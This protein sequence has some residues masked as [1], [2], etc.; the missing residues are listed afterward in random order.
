M[1]IESNNTEPPWA[2]TEQRLLREASSLGELLAGLRERI[3]TALISGPGWDALL[4]RA[5]DLPASLAAFPF[6]FELPLHD[7]TP[8][9]DLGVSLVCGSASATAYAQR[10]EDP[11]AAGIVRLLA[12][13]ARQSSALRR[14]TGPKMVLEYDIDA[15]DRRA[16]PPPG[17]F[18]YPT[19][20]P[21]YGR[22]ASRRLGDLGVVLDG[23][24]A[25]GWPWN[26]AE[27]RQV[28]RVY[29]VAGADNRVLSIGAFPARRRAIRLALA[30]FESADDVVAFLAR[31]QWPYE[32][33]TVRSTLT[34]LQDRGISCGIAVQLDVD[35]GG[36]GPTLGIGLYARD[37]SWLKEGRYWTDEPGNWEAFIACMRDEPIAVG[38]KLSALAHWSSGGA[39]QLFGKS[40]PFVLVRGVHHVKLVVTHTR[41]TQVKAYVFLMLCSSPADTRAHAALP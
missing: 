30:D 5:G 4:A 23:V 33:S 32:T 2:A 18:L 29:A 37:T 31:V 6:G 38:E 40:G 11:T 35:S 7:P 17:A 13:K 10:D 14:I 25:T 22:D 20:Q 36:V 15:T 39:R 21:L 27:R 12:E 9:A 24:A 41:L 1:A 8:R 19:E 26:V 16:H 3:A 28:E 34:R